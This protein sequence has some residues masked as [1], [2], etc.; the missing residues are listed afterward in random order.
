MQSQRY[1]T[2][3]TPVPAATGHCLCTPPP[4]QAGSF[5]TKLGDQR[6]QPPNNKT[7]FVFRSAE[8]LLADNSH[9]RGCWRLRAAPAK[10][11]GSPRGCP[12]GR[13]P[14]RGAWLSASIS[15]SAS[16]VRRMHWRPCFE[17]SS[18]AGGF[19]FGPA[20][21]T[22]HTIGSPGEL[23]TPSDDSTGRREAR[24]LQLQ[25]R[26]TRDLAL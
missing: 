25:R 24:V 22:T 14:G 11:R 18:G 17:H 1:E 21:A 12:N 16:L 3:C 9:D 23:C 13:G 4:I 15:A 5:R 7:R 26:S 19:G 10:H 2:R 6:K 20:N 8:E